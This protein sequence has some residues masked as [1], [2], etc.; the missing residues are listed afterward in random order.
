MQGKQSSGWHAPE[1][2]ALSLVGGVQLA[3][4]LGGCRH[5]RHGT[6]S[7]RLEALAGKPVRSTGFSVGQPI[8]TDGILPDPPEGHHNRTV[9]GFGRRVD[10]EDGVPCQPARVIRGE[11]RRRV[12]YVEY[13][14]HGLVIVESVAWSLSKRVWTKTPK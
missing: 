5:A 4:V 11:C 10:A 13:L 14:Y 9:F 1:V 3:L 12:I 7:I 6:D 2:L 8:P